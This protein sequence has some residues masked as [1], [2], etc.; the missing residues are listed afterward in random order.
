MKPLALDFYCKAG[1]AARGL[2]K[3]GF[4]V[5]GIDHEPQ[6]RYPY[7]FVLGD[8]LVALNI[9]LHG[10]ALTAS[11]GSSKMEIFLA[12]ANYIW[13]SPPCLDNTDLRHA[14]NARE[15]EDLIAPTRKLILKT[16]LPYTI[17]NVNSARARARLRKPFM[18]CGTSFHL[19]VSAK[20]F[21]DHPHAVRFELRR[22]RLFETNF[23]VQPTICH[24]TKSPV[25]GIYGAHCRN[26][27]KRWGGR[28]T[29]DFTCHDHN[30]LASAALG[31]PRGSMTLDELSNAIPPCYAEW[32]AKHAKNSILW[33]EEIARRNAT[34]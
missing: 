2:H 8:A 10:G 27:S 3:A 6:P 26:R 25:I 33:S 12:D 24:H 19:G 20:P 14:H 15:H 4:N 22:H 34:E 16:G 28:G 1:G 18:L 32:I 13:A 11:Y 31:I 9:L 21:A 23:P 17:E 5:V 7:P 29:A 30:D